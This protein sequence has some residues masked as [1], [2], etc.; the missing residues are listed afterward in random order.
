MSPFLP[1][2]FG[3]AA[4]LL[5]AALLY[6]GSRHCRWSWPLPLHRAGTGLGLLAAAAALALWIGALGVGAG[7]CVMLAC[8]SLA[9]IVL[10]VLA[11][12]GGAPARLPEGKG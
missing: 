5:S 4:S 1:G 6:A 11:V 3:A 7:L 10:P 8:W 9:A 2:L 12:L